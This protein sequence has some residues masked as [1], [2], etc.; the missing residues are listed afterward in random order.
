LFLAEST[1][2]GLGDLEGALKPL[3]PKPIEVF[4]PHLVIFDGLDGIVQTIVCLGQIKL[5]S[6]FPGSLS[7]FFEENLD[8]FHPSGRTR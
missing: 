6:R 5:D 8:V 2:G 3:L 7:V 4:V 1:I